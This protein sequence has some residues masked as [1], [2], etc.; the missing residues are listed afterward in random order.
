MHKHVH[1]QISRHV[2]LVKKFQFIVK[3]KKLQKLKI[4]QQM[5]LEQGTN[6]AVRQLLLTVFQDHIN[7]ILTLD[8]TKFKQGGFYMGIEI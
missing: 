1:R 8:I 2:L 7:Y 6:W 3:H 5:V 4:E